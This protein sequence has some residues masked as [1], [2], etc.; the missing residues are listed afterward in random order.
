M[1]RFSQ[2]GGIPQD[3]EGLL[4]IAFEHAPT[5]T[6]LL[7]PEGRIL[8]ANPVLC[9]LTGYS[10]S[11]LLIHDLPALFQSS[12]LGIIRDCL[13]ELNDGTRRHAQIERRMVR[14]DDRLM[15]ALLTIFPVSDNADPNQRYLLCHLH[16]VNE[17]KMAARFG[18]ALVEMSTDLLVVTNLDGGCEQISLSSQ[19]ILGWSPKELIGR[20]FFELIHPDDVDE[21][22][23]RFDGIVDS[24][25]HD[26]N[27]ACRH[28]SRDGS[29]KSIEWNAFFDQ[30]HHVYGVGRDITNRI[31][32]DDQARTLSRAIRSSDFALVVTDAT[33]PDNPIQYVNPRFEEI[34]GYASTEV[35]GRNCRFLQGS[36]R[37]QTALQTI[38]DAIREQHFCRVT[39]RNYRKDGRL[40]MNLFSLSPVPREDGS[41]GNFV[42]I[43]QDVTERYRL[44]SDLKLLVDRFPLGIVYID[45]D[46]RYRLGNKFYHGLI[47]KPEEDLDGV[48]LSDI[49]GAPAFEEIRARIDH[50]FSGEETEDEREFILPGGEKTYLHSRY[51][52]ERDAAGA[53][54]G[55]L[56]I[57]EDITEARKT[58]DTLEFQALHD[59]LTET[60]NRLGFFRVMH[61][62]LKELEDHGT[63]HALAFIDLDGF[64][65][66]NDTLGH[67][68]GDEVLRIVASVISRQVRSSD[69]VGRVGGDEFAV[70]LNGCS[71]E[72]ARQV[73]DKVLEG[74]RRMKFRS[75]GQTF[76][77]NASIGLVEIKEPRPAEYYFDLADKACYTAKRAGGGRYIVAENPDSSHG[78]SS[79]KI[80][81]SGTDVP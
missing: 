66:I 73:L 2:E 7:A 58:R 29:Y 9:E 10:R 41:I 22:R 63:T 44:A 21:A 3:I 39:L 53:V 37:D 27:F 56:M 57:I 81:K 65:P 69:S 74:I 28:R 31:G 79:A 67:S 6:A 42:G 80:P 77:L 18:N 78:A 4:R 71:R 49:L 34:T 60:L 16:D 52:P 51:I 55:C 8:W 17:R 68:K 43:V 48:P 72:V 45:R 61:R 59:P 19:R 64:K 24:G 70:F 54:I 38:R 26:C 32:E 30:G 36:D 50:T 76:E 20:N 46:Y 25:A 33:R 47:G 14:A 75:G 5:A 35:L 1:S 62:R 13:Y 12:D 23:S 11:Q 40:F 15:W